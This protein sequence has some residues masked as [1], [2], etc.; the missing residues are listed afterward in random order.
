[1][2]SCKVKNS[3]NNIADNTLSIFFN[4]HW[5]KLRHLVHIATAHPTTSSIQIIHIKQDVFGRISENEIYGF[6]RSSKPYID[7]FVTMVG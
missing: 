7:F 3:C 6:S 2:P 1:M 5:I 4:V